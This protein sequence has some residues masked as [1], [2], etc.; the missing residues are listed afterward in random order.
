MNPPVLL[1]DPWLY[2]KENALLRMRMI[3]PWEKMIYISTKCQLDLLKWKIIIKVLC[4][5]HI[6]ELSN[7]KTDTMGKDSALTMAGPEEDIMA[8]QEPID[9]SCLNLSEWEKRRVQTE[10]FPTWGIS[11]QLLIPMFPWPVV[12]AGHGPFL[13][14]DCIAGLDC[15]L[16]PPFI[17]YLIFLDLLPQ[18]SAGGNRNNNTSSLLYNFQ[19]IKSF[20]ITQVKVH[21]PLSLLQ[22]L[23]HLGQTV[24]TT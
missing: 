21:V 5:H 18:V 11:K 19:T 17:F 10:N 20:P 8:S 2:L 13:F 7:D 24:P 14:S 16:N 15:Y 23:S 22:T 4:L 3:W 6:R 12:W 1:P 9:M